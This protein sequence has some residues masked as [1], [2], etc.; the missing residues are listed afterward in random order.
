LESL[1][2]LVGRLAEFGLG[3]RE[4][5]IILAG[6]ALPLFPV[7]PGDTIVVE[8]PPFGTSRAEVGP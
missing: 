6:S 7:G 8:A 5:Q 4:G 3:L 1:R 2:W